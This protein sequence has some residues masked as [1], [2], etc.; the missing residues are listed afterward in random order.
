MYIAR[1]TSK[2]GTT[3]TAPEKVLDKLISELEFPKRMGAP[4]EFASLVAHIVQNAYIN[5]ELI[6]LD[7]G[8]RARPR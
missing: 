2:D 4:A 1:I 5:G 6:R 3:F 8:V 7:G